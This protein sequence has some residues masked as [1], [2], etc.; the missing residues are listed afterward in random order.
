LPGAWEADNVGAVACHAFLRCPI[1]RTLF[2]ACLFSAVSLAVMLSGATG[3]QTTL[4]S[5]SVGAG[6]NLEFDMLAK[7]V[8]KLVQ[9]RL[10]LRDGA[11]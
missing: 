10:P 9:T 11:D 4:G 8:R 5:K 7:H 2:A 1:I 3:Q 6:V